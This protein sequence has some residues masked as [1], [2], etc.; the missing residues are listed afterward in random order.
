MLYHAWKGNSEA[1]SAAQQLRSINKEL[2]IS[3]QGDA[4]AEVVLRQ[5]DPQ[6]AILCGIS[7]K[8]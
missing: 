6:S 8:V 1:K 5:L 7:N 2:G 4:D 3:L